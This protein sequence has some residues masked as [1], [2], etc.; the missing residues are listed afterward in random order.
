MTRI[1]VIDNHGQFTH[2]EHRA[3][4]DLGVDTELIDNDVDPSEVDADGIVLSGGPDMDRAGRSAEYLDGDVPVLGICLGM[5]LIA[6]ELGGTT[7]SG[8]Y[9]GYADVTVEILDDDDPLIGS[10]A[11]E[12]RVWASHADEVKTLPDGFTHT[13]TSDV[14]GVEAMSDTDRDLYGVQ[15]HPEVIH[16]EQ[17]EEVFENFVDICE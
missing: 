6:E 5:Q 17:G 11:P 15:W 16:T 12:T 9:G 4:R 7:G 14:C 10:L 8:E 1:V 13:G 2:L 3:L